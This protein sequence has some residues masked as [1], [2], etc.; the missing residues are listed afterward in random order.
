[1]ERIEK[2]ERKKMEYRILGTTT[3]EHHLIIEADS[4]ED[5]LAKARSLEIDA[6]F[7]YESDAD[8]EVLDEVFLEQKTEWHRAYTEAEYEA[9]FFKD[10]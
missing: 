8:V 7:L 6:D 3:I 4:C 2:T 10:E 5:A 9:E 1:M